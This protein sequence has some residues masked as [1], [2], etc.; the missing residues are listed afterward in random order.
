[1]EKTYVTTPI[2]LLV[3]GG[4]AGCF[5]VLL[6]LIPKIKTP[7]NF[8]IIIVLHRKSGL[9]SN[10][11]DAFSHKTKLK[12]FECEDKDTIVAGNIYFAP[13][14]YHLLIEKDGTVSLDYSEKVNY[15][16]PSIDVTFKNT[17]DLY[18]ARMAGLLLS[19]ANSDGAEGLKYIHQK[20][21]T[22][23]VQHPDSAEI[24]TMPK[25]ALNLFKPDF[26]ANVDD[27]INLIN[28]F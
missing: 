28:N 10:I 12:I 17:A 27:I 13:P 20:S 14:D 4:S 21:G 1:M 26:I 25:E 16:R 9:N 22:T 7:V 2:D 15:S 19:G 3:I 11:V 18:G 23:I 24:N 8:A 6:Q 5:N